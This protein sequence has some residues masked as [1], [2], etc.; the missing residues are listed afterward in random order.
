MTINEY[1]EKRAKV[2]PVEAF[3]DRIAHGIAKW[4]DEIEMAAL[5]VFAYVTWVVITV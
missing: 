3:C 2:H 1:R 4:S 5:I